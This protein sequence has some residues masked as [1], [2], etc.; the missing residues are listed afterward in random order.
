MVIVIIKGNALIVCVLGGVQPVKITVLI[1]VPAVVAH[2]RWI[3]VVV[4]GNVLVDTG[5]I[6]LA[7]KSVRRIAIQA[8]VAEIVVVVFGD[9]KNIIGVLVY[10]INPVHLTVILVHA[11][12]KVAAA[13]RITVTKDIGAIVIVTNHVQSTVIT[14]LAM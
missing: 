4:I 9:A 13:N 2:A 7:R 6:V 8:V 12:E 1:A 3:R 10:V 5:G 11:C 14:V